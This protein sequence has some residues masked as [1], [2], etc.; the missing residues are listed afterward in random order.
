M[1]WC[2]GK[3][4]VK[5]SFLDAITFAFCVFGFFFS[6]LS[7]FVVSSLGNKLVGKFEGF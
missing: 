6:S 5:T 7:S 1:S 3:F 4:E 2:L